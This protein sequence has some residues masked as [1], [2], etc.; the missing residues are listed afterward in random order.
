[1]KKYLLLALSLTGLLSMNVAQAVTLD[2]LK[3]MSPEERATYMQGL[4]SDELD[5]QRQEIRDSV[6]NMTEEERSEM[7][8]SF[9]TE[10]RV[11][12]REKY[13]NRGG[14]SR[15]VSSYGFGG[16]PK[17]GRGGPPWK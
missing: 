10:E 14:G 1:M 7:R 17:G 11:A 13:G 3:A 16:R 15:P 8:K 2:A 4:N 9:S 5:K 6:K 12:R